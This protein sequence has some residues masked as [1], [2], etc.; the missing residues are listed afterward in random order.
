MLQLEALGIKSRYFWLEHFG[1]VYGDITVLSKKPN[2]AKFTMRDPPPQA[3]KEEE[4]VS[5]K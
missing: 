4:F 5:W 3:P 1:V 2:Y